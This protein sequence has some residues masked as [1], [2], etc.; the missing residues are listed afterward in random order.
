MTRTE[1]RSAPITENDLQ[2]WIDLIPELDWAFAVTYAEGAPHEYICDRTPGITPDEFV[3][4]ARV[5]HAFGEPQKFY[6]RTRIY[7]VHDGWK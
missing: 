1:L 4:A 3:R 7:L 2:W 6:R 5:I